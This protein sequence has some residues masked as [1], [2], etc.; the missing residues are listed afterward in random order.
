[1]QVASAARMFG[2]GQDVCPPPSAVTQDENAPK[3]AAKP[4]AV[5]KEAIPHP[6]LNYSDFA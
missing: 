6:L 5:A 1:M 3:R 4:K 2:G